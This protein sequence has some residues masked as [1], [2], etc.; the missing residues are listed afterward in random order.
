MQRTH[1]NEGINTYQT[2]QGF[3]FPG[4]VIQIET[5]LYYLHV[6]YYI[7]VEQLIKKQDLIAMEL[8]DKILRR[9]YKYGAISDRPFKS[10]QSIFTR[11]TN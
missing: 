4:Q 7:S 1:V 5:A 8:D 6:L 2:H 3:L 11:P 9:M 10:F